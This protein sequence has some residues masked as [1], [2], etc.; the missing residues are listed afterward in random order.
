MKFVIT[1]L[2]DRLRVSESRIVKS[3][4][5]ITA[6]DGLVRAITPPKPVAGAR[7]SGCTNYKTMGHTQS[8]FFLVKEGT[9]V[10][11]VYCAFSKTNGIAGQFAHL[12]NIIYK[13]FCL[14]ILQL[15]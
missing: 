2:D 3:K 8:G 7:P 10:K 15:F 1:A 14:I 13:I 12:K 5:N 4:S 9:K 11:T 6:L